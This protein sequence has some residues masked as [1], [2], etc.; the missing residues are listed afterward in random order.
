MEFTS[1]Q[2]NALKARGRVLVSAAAG[3]GK[4]AVL[5]ERAVNMMTDKEQPIDA[6]RLL[7]VTFTNAAAAE[8]KSRISKKLRESATKLGNFDLLKRQQYRLSVAKICTIDSFCLSLIRENFFELGISPDVKIADNSTLSAIKSDALSTIVNRL[9]EENS[10][11]FQRLCE[12]LG[13]ENAEN[14][15]RDA[16]MSVYE[17]TCNHPYPDEYLDNLVKMYS[18]FDI[19]NSLWIKT[20]FDNI[21]CDLNYSKTMIDKCKR[22]AESD[23]DLLSKYTECINYY[24]KIIEYAIDVCDKNDWDKLYNC[25]NAFDPPRLP[26]YKGVAADESAKIKEFAGEIRKIIRKIPK[27]MQMDSSGIIG[28]MA[29]LTPVVKLLADAV[30][31]FITEYQ[32]IKTE[33]NLIEFIDAEYMA[34]KLLSENHKPTKL[35]QELSEFYYEVMVDEYQDVNDLQNTIFN[36]LSDSGKKIFMVGDVK[37]SIY[38]FRN[39]NPE[40]FLKNRNQLPLYQDEKKDGKVIMSGNFR[41]APE[42]CNF[43]NDVFVNLMTV[44]TAGMDYTDEDKLCPMQEFA[45]NVQDRVVYEMHDC[46]SSPEDMTLPMLEAKRIVEIIKEQMDASPFIKTNTGV[47]K[48]E[49]S[50][51]AILLRDGKYVTEIK[52]ALDKAGIPNSTKIGGNLLD[53]REI[54]LLMS[55]LETVNNPYRDINTV[56]VMMSPIF[57]FTADEVAK[58]RLENDYKSVFSSLTAQKE[59]NENFRNFCEKINRYRDWSHTMSTSDLL[60]R[61]CD[62]CSFFDIALNFKS[63]ERS[64]NNI[65]SFINIA[66]NFDSGMDCDLVRFLRYVK[67]ASETDRAFSVKTATSSTNAVQIV[68]MH[69]SKGLQYPICIL[70]A[71]SNK[72]NTSDQR[73]GLQLDSS[74]GFGM[75]VCDS[76]NR[77]RYKTVPQ[78]AIKIKK[79]KG[80]I[81]EELCIFYVAMT[82]AVEKLY[83]LNSFKNSPKTPDTIF[84]DNTYE[85]LHSSSF[86]DFLNLCDAANRVMK[87]TTYNKAQIENETK[88]TQLSEQELAKIQNRLSYTYP[89]SVLNTVNAKQTASALSHQ[90]EQIIRLNNKPMF[91]KSDKISAA[92]KGTACH[93]FM[94]CCDFEKAEKSVENEIIRLK[95]EGVLTELQAKAIQIKK[96]K[97]FF[98]NDFYKNT[99]AVADKVLKEQH[100]MITLPASEVYDD[101]PIELVD[102]KIVIQGAADLVVI[103]D[104]TL[105]IVDYKTDRAVSQDELIA[106]YKKQL[107]IYSKSFKQIFG[108]SKFSAIIY[109]FYLQKTICID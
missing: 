81:S 64:R 61:I 105:Y 22:F 51:I 73:S 42:I 95:N 97:P 102:E 48:T 82:R 7:I 65:L 17:E 38:R 79:H 106:K 70:A 23:D 84:C 91:K 33:R 53:Y 77:I 55:V 20:I 46:T 96:I 92:Q 11:E 60:R 89:F 66:D 16:I 12:T 45:E 1:E 49:Y 69:S 5:V 87:M 13:E 27:T 74:L 86:A 9:F 50:D 99:I 19:K 3:S 78:Q 85:I 35:A 14:N 4:T 21:K 24:N 67:R 6:D 76:K 41:S 40:I 103:K 72:M 39:A 32:S 37:Q 63:G 93:K 107:E 54:S 101:I 26:V 15:L 109:S 2:K 90:A 88:E 58:L 80:Q 56:A 28:D 100:F 59:K 68:T 47:R 44:D 34:L 31:M 108:C 104:D 52:S 83:M 71:L 98:E 8:M 43:V 75:S 25:A 18:Q 10:E 30:K 57:K 94:E 62:D 29:H 36:L